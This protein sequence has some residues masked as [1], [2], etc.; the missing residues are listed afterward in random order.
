MFFSDPSQELPWEDDLVLFDENEVID[1]PHWFDDV[2][3]LDDLGNLDKFNLEGYDNNLFGG[4]NFVLKPKITEKFN[5]K[6]KSEERTYEFKLKDIEFKNFF[7]ASTQITLFFEK[8]FDEYI[9][10]IKAN[11]LVR[12]CMDHDS[13]VQAINTPFMERKEMSAKM[14]L[15]EFSGCFQSR[16]PLALR[17][18]QKSHEF[19]LCVIT[20][21]KYIITGGSN[22]TKTKKICKEKKEILDM[23]DF[24]ESSR[25]VVV[26]QNSDNYCLIRALFVA[27]AFSDQDKNAKNL[28]RKNNKKLNFLVNNFVKEMKIPN[29][30]LDLSFCEQLEDH[31]KDYMI[32]VYDTVQ[33]DSVILYPLGERLEKLKNRK[34]TKFIRIVY[35]NDNHFNLILKPTSYF[36]NSYF[37][38][39]CRVKY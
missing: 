8:I 7:E 4:F 25:F 1:E 22:E 19:S 16:T 35:N 9:A 11:N 30:H 10:P 20:L 2:D 18:R 36:G 37:C 5:K 21:P 13:F 31:F 27:K 6:W 28:N 17:D 3:F 15:E 29:R 24:I 33:N 12:V 23:N 39:I 32:T 38:E 14:F 26:I 34:F